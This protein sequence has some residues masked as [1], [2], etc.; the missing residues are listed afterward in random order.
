MG[1]SV[2]N[3]LQSIGLTVSD[4]VFVVMGATFL[5]V[6]YATYA[7]ARS[8]R[9]REQIRQRAIYR[10]ESAQDALNDR[11]SLRHQKL[12]GTKKLMSL[13]SS[14]FVPGDEKSV[15]DVRGTGEI[16]MA[17]WTPSINPRIVLLRITSPRPS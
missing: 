12:A 2:V 6:S 1:A 17:R 4:L 8:L 16:F 11:R 13:V 7:I 5:F 15:S 10:G 14:N 3:Y 9:A